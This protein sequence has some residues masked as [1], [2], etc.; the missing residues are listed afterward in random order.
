MPS[1]TDKIAIDNPSLDRRVKLTPEDKLEIKKEYEQGLISINGLARKWNVSKRSIQFIL[2]PE[3]AEHAKK[4]YAERRKDKRY[5]DKDKHKEYTKKH[6]NYK[7]EL[8]EKGA[9]QTEPGNN[10][11]PI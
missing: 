7:K 6:R 1:K 5:Y 2:F 9:L 8:Y 3:R 4:L 10:D 11:T